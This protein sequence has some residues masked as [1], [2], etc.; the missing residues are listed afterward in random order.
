MPEWTLA[1]GAKIKRTEL[2][3]QFGG[4][5]YSGISSSARTP[6]VFLF[7]DPASGEQHGYFDRW[8]DG[9]FHYSG[10]GQHGAATSKVSL[11]MDRGHPSL[12]AKP[13]D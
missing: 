2:H 8:T 9:A 1:V 10:E 6:N 5:R 7:S 12:A 13:I 11:R 4:S 3:Q